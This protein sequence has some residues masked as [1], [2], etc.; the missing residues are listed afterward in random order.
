MHSS[1]YAYVVLAMHRSSTLLHIIL[2]C[3]LLIGGIK[4]R[5]SS[6]FIYLF[7][8]N[9]AAASALYDTTVEL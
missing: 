1:Y 3:F 2:L 5:R 9:L 8:R 6:L 7:T 4:E